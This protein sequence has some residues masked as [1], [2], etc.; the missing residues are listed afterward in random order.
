V[1]TEQTGVEPSAAPPTTRA[2]LREAG[3]RLLR[4]TLGPTLCFYVGWK[5]EGIWLGVIMGTVFAFAAY[6]YERRRG[7]PGMIARLVL[8]FVV[9]QAGVGLATGSAKAYLIQPTILGGVNGLAWLGSVAMRRPLAAVFAREVF[10]FDEAIRATPEFKRVFMLVS[11]VWGMFFLGFAAIQAAVL[12]IVGVDAYVALR[13]VDALLILTLIT[14][15]VRVVIGRLGGDTLP[16]TE[17][18]LGEVGL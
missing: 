2:I 13:V 18:H 15:S 14:W 6:R 11:A 4:D 7:R 8:A 17:V 16:I 3:P 1:G 9:L 10:P 12:L 5:T